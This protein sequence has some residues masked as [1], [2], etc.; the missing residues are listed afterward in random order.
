MQHK[1]STKQFLLLWGLISPGCLGLIAAVLQRYQVMWYP[2]YPDMRLSIGIYLSYWLLLG[3]LQG[4]LLFWRFN[5]RRWAA[6]W[7]IVTSLTGFLV[8]LAHDLTIALFGID[9]RGQGILILILSLPCLVVLGG[10][11]L[12]L[13]QFSLIQDR[14][15]THQKSNWLTLIWFSIS[16]LSWMIGFS[17][18]FLG[19]QAL[20]NLMAFVTIGSL[21]KGRFIQ[22]YRNC[23]T[24]G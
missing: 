1:P 18:V 8:M 12:G 24:R 13:M 5:D 2:A 11:I 7:A 19:G 20:A 15:K 14:Y 3:I 17:G 4:G 22:K 10:L 9:T 23:S 16:L 6:Q 21:L